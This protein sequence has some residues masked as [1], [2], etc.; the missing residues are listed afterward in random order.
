MKLNLLTALGLG[1]SSVSASGSCSPYAVIASG[2]TGIAV[3]LMLS[4]LMP[5]TVSESLDNVIK[6][7]IRRL[8]SAILGEERFNA[9]LG[10]F[11]YTFRREVNA[12]FGG[13]LNGSP[14]RLAAFGEL[15]RR[16]SF[17]AVVETGTYR[18]EST[19]FFA[20][21]GC[22]VYSS[23]VD[24]RFWSYSRARLRSRSNAH[25]YLGDSRES[26]RQLIQD[27][28]MPK[29][30]VFFYLDAHWREDLPL[31]EEVDL[32]F[33]HWTRPVVMVD[34]F[35]VPDDP[36]YKF[37]DYG[38]GKK[39]SL[40]YLNPVAHLGFIPFFPALPSSEEVGIKRGWV[41]LACDSFSIDQL[42]GITQLRE[43]RQPNA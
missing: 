21:T 3:G 40:A 15:N 18:G 39:L 42:R 11:D 8:L 4:K 16:C 37:D 13:P 22:P 6:G 34:D 2:V 5:T 1:F 10:A 31:R 9:W 14:V 36:G 25:L 33:R 12:R 27:S 32:I 26:L 24:P 38:E 23:E 7:F 17:A 29:D 30:R 28:A 41:V 43:W 19:L 20:D 35:Q